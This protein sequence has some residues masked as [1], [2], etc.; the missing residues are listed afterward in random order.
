MCTSC[1]RVSCKFVRR[2]WWGAGGG[3]G[4]LG[5][6]NSNLLL[7]SLLSFLSHFMPDYPSQLQTHKLTNS[8]CEAG[9]TCANCSI[10]VFGLLK[11]SPLH[12]RTGGWV[13]PNMKN[14]KSE[15]NFEVTWKSH[16][17]YCVLFCTVIL[18]LKR[19]L[20]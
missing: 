12:Y 14:P 20:K 7:L 10:A 18:H 6:L 1:L 4:A 17:D 5:P 19:C 13:N 8:D 2:T 11:G 15:I 16:A 3:L 9:I